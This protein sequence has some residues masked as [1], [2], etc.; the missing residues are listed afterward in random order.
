[1]WCDDLRPANVLMNQDD[2][3]AAVIDWEFSHSAPAEFLHSPPWWLLLQAPEDWRAGLDDWVAKYE[4]RLATFLR[5]LESR[6]RQSIH[7]GLLKKSDILSTRMRESWESGQFW[8]TYAARRSWAFDAIYWKFL[9]EKYFGENKSGHFEERLNLLSP[10]QVMAMEG[11]VAR[12][13]EE[14][15]QSSLVDW[16]ESG[17]EARLPENIFDAD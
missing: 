6:E 9:D 7:E 8:L 13:L 15:A 16:Y 3:I 17:S 14:K 5:A 4:P 2:N 10:R 11:F 1:M 12:K